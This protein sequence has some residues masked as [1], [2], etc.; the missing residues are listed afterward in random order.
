MK[1]NVKYGAIVLIAFVFFYICGYIKLP[2]KMK[3]IFSGNFD[4]I[5]QCLTKKIGGAYALTIQFESPKNNRYAQLKM[6]TYSE[7]KISQ[8]NCSLFGEGK[9]TSYSVIDSVSKKRT[10]PINDYKKLKLTGE[11]KN[12]TVLIEIFY[13]INTNDDS[14]ILVKFLP[15]SSS[16]ITTLR[17]TFISP[18][19]GTNGSVKLSKQ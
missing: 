19:T 1:D 17:G 15:F 12:D 9:K 13:P 18:K 16:A 11:I 5:D 6:E 7:I 4:L 10:K 8:N 14:K 3:D 2:Q